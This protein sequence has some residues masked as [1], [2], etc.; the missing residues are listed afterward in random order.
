MADMF[1]SMMKGGN[2][3][4]LEGFA[5]ASK[6]QAQGFADHMG[7]RRRR[8]GTRRHRRGTRRARH[9]REKE[10][11][12]GGRRHKKRAAKTHRRRRHARRNN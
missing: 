9:G 10:R 12:Q 2:E 7:G 11:T 6:A 1:N 8:R 4:L 5:A 3:E